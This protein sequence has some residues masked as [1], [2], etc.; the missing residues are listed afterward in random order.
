MRI[1][2]VQKYMG[3]KEMLS[4][5]VKALIMVGIPND[6]SSLHADLSSVSKLYENQFYL[7]EDSKKKYPYITIDYASTAVPVNLPLG[8][9]RNLTDRPTE[10]ILKATGVNLYDLTYDNTT[11]IHEVKGVLNKVEHTFLSTE[12]QIVGGNQIQFI[13]P[14]YPDDD[15]YFVVTYNIKWVVTTKGGEFQD[16]LIVNVRARDY[17]SEVSPTFTNGLKLATQIVN[18]VLK[19]FLYDADIT[20]VIFVNHS[21]VV[22]ISELEVTNMVYRLR[23]DIQ[24]RYVDHKAVKVESV[25][26]VDYTLNIGT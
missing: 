16:N 15:T 26:T 5:I 3:W 19:W 9:K 20:G 10:S 12:Y 8:G 18:E 23:F 17:R 4:E 25:E 7:I 22:D 1:L 14:N 6:F 2:E 11:L 24:V 13:G 21:D